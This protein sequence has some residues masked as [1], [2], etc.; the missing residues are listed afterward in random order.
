MQ[1]GVED[2][3]VEAPWRGQGLGPAE[4]TPEVCSLSLRVA[5]CT[6]SA[7][8]AVLTCPVLQSLE[9][10]ENLSGVQGVILVGFPCIAQYT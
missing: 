2:R 6:Q 1:P 4:G 7:Q 10:L 8:P 5:E 3:K 9:Q